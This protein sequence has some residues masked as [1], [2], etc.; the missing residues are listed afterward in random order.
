MNSMRWC[1]IALLGLPAGA[2]AGGVTDAQLTQ[3]SSLMGFDDATASFVTQ[4]VASEPLF[5]KF[6][7]EQRACTAG[8]MGEKIGENT[9]ARLRTIF[10]D[11]EIAQAWIDLPKTAG[12]RR[13]L[14]YV[15]AGVKAKMLGQAPASAATFLA[16]MPPDDAVELLKFMASPAGLAFSS[17]SP[18][19]PTRFT[20]AQQDALGGELIER[21][22]VSES[23]FS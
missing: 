13:Y 23:D 20:P 10:K 15:S 7:D 1:L 6:T 16:G 18:G 5:Q 3:L 22:K 19:S 17:A 9:R 14:E 8:L 2:M 21:C 4:K 11:D 12:G